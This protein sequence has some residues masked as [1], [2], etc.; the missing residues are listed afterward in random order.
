MTDDRTTSGTGTGPSP[1]AAA[2]LTAAVITSALTAGSFFV[3]ACAVMPALARRG[4]RVYVDVMRDIN[5]V[6][7]NPLFFAAFL[8][9]PVLTA[10]S[11]RQLR[12]RPGARGWVRAALIAHVL[13][14]LVTAAVNVP[15]NDGLAGTGDPAVLRA[16]FEDR[17]VLW[18]AVRAVLSAGA[19][20]CLARAAIRL[21]ADRRDEARPP[22]PA[23]PGARGPQRAARSG[24]RGTP[25]LGRVQAQAQAAQT[26]SG[27]RPRD[28]APGPPEPAPGC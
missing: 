23:V 4:D 6:I 26:S 19:V 24:E 15:L 16:R 14:F 5:D 17:W 27:L 22:A 12:D 9:A 8:G 2:V 13:A 18:N 20:G 1:T 11:A 3:F 10:L 25:G 21:T 28:E 7:Q